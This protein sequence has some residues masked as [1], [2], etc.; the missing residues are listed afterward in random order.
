[1][2][3][4]KFTFPPNGATIAS[5]ETFTLTMAIRNRPSSSPT[6]C[7]LSADPYP[8]PPVVTGNF[9]NPQTNYF[10]AP[11]QTDGSGTLIGH[12]HAVIEE[13]DGLD[14]V[15]PSDPRNFAF[16]KGLNDAARAPARSICRPPRVSSLTRLAF[17]A[18]Q[19]AASSAPRVRPSF[20]TRPTFSQTD[21]RARPLCL[22][23]S[24]TGGLAAG[25]YKLC[26]INTAAVRPSFAQ[27]S[28]RA[29]PRTDGAHLPHPR[30]H[31]S[32]T[33]SRRSSPSPSTRRST[34]RPPSLTPTR[35]RSPLVRR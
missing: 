34:V 6:S 8:P 33:T 35:A 29:C 4:S 11:A 12:S 10:A 21:V 14:S 23:L 26:S 17:S 30:P 13:I 22:L 25:T 2:P 1:M 19:R 20:P 31:A 15:T 7:T 27:S 28:A 16:F 3:S 9:V 32:R 5:D 18:S 24:V